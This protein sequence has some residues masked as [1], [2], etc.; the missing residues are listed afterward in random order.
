VIRGGAPAQLKAKLVEHDLSPLEDAFFY[1]NGG[2]EGRA[3]FDWQV[4]QMPPELRD[5]WTIHQPGARKA[6]Q[7]DGHG[8]AEAH[9]GDVH[10]D[11]HAAARNGQSVTTWTDGEHTLTVTTEAEKPGRHLVAKDKND[12]VLFDGDLD[13]PGARDKLPTIV[14]DKLEKM[15]AAGVKPPKAA[16][17][18]G[19]SGNLLPAD[20]H[21]GI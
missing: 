20:D 8:D 18:S 15:E 19:A 10:A 6:P 5:W 17:P 21:D 14:K 11:A 13:A 1:R 2:P 7:A 3:F 12:A 16:G 9:G 4:R